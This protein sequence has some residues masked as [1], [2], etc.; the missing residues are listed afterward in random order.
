MMRKEDYYDLP[1]RIHYL[2]RVLLTVMVFFV[3]LAGI[4][5]SAAAAGTITIK[6]SVPEF[7]DNWEVKLGL[8]YVGSYEELNDKLPHT[9]EEEAVQAQ[10]IQSLI[11]W[12]QGLNL[13]RKSDAVVDPKARSATFTNAENGV[14]L[15]ELLSGPSEFVMSPLLIGLQGDEEVFEASPKCSFL[16]KA[17][18]IKRWD[19]EDNRDG[20][21]K[22]ISVRLLQD[23]APY[24]DENGQG[25]TR[26]LTESNGWNAVL[27]GLPKYRVAA[28]GEW[29]D[30]RYSFEE[31]P[32]P[33][34]YVQDETK[35]SFDKEN[36]IWI[37]EIKNVHT[38]L[39]T[40]RTV[41]KVWK[42]DEK[43]KESRPGSLKVALY[44]VSGGGQK[45]V[46]DKD[47][48]A[49]SVTLNEKNGWTGSVSD[50]PLYEK[51]ELLEYLWVEEEIPDYSLD[52]SDSQPETDGN[53]NTVVTTTL[54][55]TY[56]PETTQSSVKKVWNDNGD[57]DAIRPA[58]VEV[59]LYQDGKEYGKAYALNAENKWTVTVKDLPRYVPGTDRKE[60][61]YTWQEVSVPRGY[62]AEISAGNPTVI[63]NTHTP[64]TV[65]ITIRKKWDD[66]SNRDRLRP[67]SVTIRLT[68]N[69]KKLSETIEL[70]TANADPSDSSVWSYTRKGLPKYYKDKEGKQAEIQYSIQEVSKVEGYTSAAPVKNRDGYLVVNK[71]EPETTEITV[72]K[73][74]EDDNNADGI[75]PDK[76]YV[77]LYANGDP[78]GKT[79]KIGPGL[80]GTKT[81]GSQWTYTWKNLPTK[82]ANGNAIKYTVDELNLPDGYERTIDTGARGEFI[83]YN[84]HKPEEGSLRI[85]KGVT[86]NGKAAE[87]TEADGTYSF[88]VTGP[89]SYSKTFSISVVGGKTK[90]VLISGLRPGVYT[91]EE[92]VPFDM[93][94]AGSN[95][96]E[97][98]VTGNDAGGVQTASFI[99]DKTVTP[100]PTPAPTP[101]VTPTETPTPT[102]VP[103]TS[104]AG[105]KIW[106]DENNI[107][108]LRPSSIT[109]RLYANGQEQGASATWSSTSGNSWTYSFDNLPAVDNT[110]KQIAYTVRED[111]VEGYTSKVSGTIITNTL[112]PRTPEKYTSFSGTKTWA[113]SG[114]ESGSRP[115]Y[116]TVQ[117]LR[118]GAVADTRTVTAATGWSYRF[119]NVP[120]DDGYGHHYTYTVHEDGVPG[121]YARQDGS[122]FSNYRLPGGDVPPG[123]PGRPW[124]PGQPGQP[125]QPP[126]SPYYQP[127]IP[128]RYT[129]TTPPPFREKTEEELEELIDI[130]D[131][132][133][134]LWGGLL[135]TGDDMPVY[136]FIF[137]GIGVAALLVLFLFGRRRRDT[138]K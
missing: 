130:F 95:N 102:P 128:E 23:G 96:V 115:S 98:T 131:Y 24:V 8:Y 4:A 57:Q 105:T 69:I 138:A 26:T 48:N 113:D 121:Y 16:T 35:F 39:K 88:I 135:G 30:I 85:S 132:D 33:E 118:D 104:V 59:R 120:E 126:E 81:E 100:T 13:T 103:T 3:F 66:D 47:G 31:T 101:T 37:T 45:P 122:N 36:N 7:D 129:P 73:A 28:T 14:Y 119:D 58:S 136:P 77:H 1:Q 17:E 117:L 18:V 67:S 46:T 93:T 84:T 82:D 19:D 125:G 54:T 44:V 64:A 11:R 86:V 56:S 123:Q 74:W 79:V 91:I 10:K 110:G 60:Y 62:R 15:V 2:R 61:K 72:T 40:K 52:Y 41:R 25:V 89:D 21:R 124:E 71:H 109:V 134:P 29:I 127:P 38:P 90:S 78:Y 9:D 6:F 50:L 106:D 108:G 107:H 76:V 80:S 22:S 5:Q 92:D 63:T 87:G 83:I 12:A 49:V 20:L 111:P 112:I 65:D 99:N 70:S 116:I 51:G 137:A 32:V 42:N 94:L 75:R 68:D 53:G 133:T 27:E 34:G 114:N 43:N 97:V 55:N